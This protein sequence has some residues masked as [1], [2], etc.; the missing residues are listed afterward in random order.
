MGVAAWLKMRRGLAEDIARA[1]GLRW[2][3]WTENAETGRA[4]G[5]YVFNDQ[6]SA[7][8]YCRMHGRGSASSAFDIHAEIFDMNETLGKIT[9]APQ[10]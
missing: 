1:P 7:E 3:I 9:R 6:A 2:K 10:G 4:G 5:I 8:A